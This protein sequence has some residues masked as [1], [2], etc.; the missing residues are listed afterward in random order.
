MQCIHTPASPARYVGEFEYINAHSAGKFVVELNGRLNKCV[1][2]P[3]FN[4]SVKEIERWTTRL[5]PSTQNC[6]TLREIIDRKQIHEVLVNVF[7][8]LVAN[9]WA[10]F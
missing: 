4:T 7:L 2:S 5:L 6:M 3:R 1:I 10:R 8:C 9:N